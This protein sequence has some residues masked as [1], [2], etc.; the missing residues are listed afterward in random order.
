MVTRDTRY[1]SGRVSAQHL[2][3]IPST[4]ELVKNATSTFTSGW[5][6]AGEGMQV[7]INRKNFG[8]LY[9]N[10]PDA[11]GSGLT[12]G[13]AGKGMVVWG[14][15]VVGKNSA[16][17]AKQL[18]MKLTF[19]DISD[20]ALTKAKDEL[21]GET[22]K[23]SAKMIPEEKGKV[24]DLLSSEN[25]DAL[26]IGVLVKGAAAPRLLDKKDLREIN[27]R[28]QE[29]EL[30]PLVIADA[31]IDQGGTIEGE[32]ATTHDNP[33]A[34]IEGS[35][36]CTVA[37]IPGSRFTAAY[38][39]KMLQEATIADLKRTIKAQ[40]KGWD[41]ALAEDPLLATAI[42]TMGGKITYPEVADEFS[43]QPRGTVD[44]QVASMEKPKDGKIKLVI[45]SPIKPYEHRVGLLPSGVKDIS[46][47]AKKEGIDLEIAVDV[48]LGEAIPKTPEMEEI[49]TE[50]YKKA[51]GKVYDDRDE[52]MGGD[53]YASHVY[54]FTKEPQGDEL[55]NIRQGSAVHTYFHYTGFPEKL[56]KWAVDKKVTSVAFETRE[57]EKGGLP[58]LAP[59]S[60]VDGRSNTLII[61]AMLNPEIMEFRKK[62][63]LLAPSHQIL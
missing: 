6:E 57:D 52:L 26:N 4:M 32:K 35:P 28:R 14:A 24:L 44:E 59:M 11:K 56:V 34:F 19:I 39:S 42:N 23:V 17:N 8:R 45:P 21:G 9:E 10:F 48:R 7:K 25:V 15:G 63:D 13:L 54:H 51:G 55:D 46:D 43:G 22:L 50:A 20:A 2:D 5:M 3:E 29:K 36:V 60:H 33:V 18:G 62:K 16:E 12:E 49:S 58:T 31:A 61:A 47:W 1:I 27:R 40:A 53:G 41:K 38:A 37:N 30:K